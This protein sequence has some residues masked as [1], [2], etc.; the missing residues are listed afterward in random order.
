MFLCSA[1]DDLSGTRSLLTAVGLLSAEAVTARRVLTGTFLAV[2]S[3][4]LILLLLTIVL[5]GRRTVVFGALTVVG[6]VLADK[7][8][9]TDL[10]VFAVRAVGFDVFVLAGMIVRT[11]L[12]ESGLL[13]V[14]AF[15]TDGLVLTER[16]LLATAGFDTELLRLV[17]EIVTTFLED[18]DALIGFVM[19]RLPDLPAISI[20]MLDGLDLLDLLVGGELILEEIADL[21]CDL[22]AALEGVFAGAERFAGEAERDGAGLAG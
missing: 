16:G 11:L 6:F 7:I 9:V 13:W 8:V 4:L 18:L 10:G 20:V 19:V 14:A 3:G 12:L 2:A 21:G 1:T 5:D 17:G 22:G 15:E